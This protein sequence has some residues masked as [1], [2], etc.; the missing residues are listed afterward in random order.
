[1]H[2]WPTP[3]APLQKLAVVAELVSPDLLS[4]RARAQGQR[5]GL[6][7]VRQ[8]GAGREETTGRFD[9]LETETRER[10]AQAGKTDYRWSGQIFEPVGYVALIVKNQGSDRVFVVAGDSGDG[11]TDAVLAERRIADEVE[12]KTKPWASLYSPK[13][14]GSVI[15]S[16]LSMA[17]HDI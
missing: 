13:R 12:G 1:M 16:L 9:E 8:A 17:K 2:G 3:C 4:C 7:A 6:S 14:L 10:F 15:R 5:R 11:L